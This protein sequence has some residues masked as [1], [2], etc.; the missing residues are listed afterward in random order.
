M[1]HTTSTLPLNHISI[2]P[3]SDLNFGLE[4]DCISQRTGFWEKLEVLREATPLR[5]SD[6]KLK[7]DHFHQKES[8]CICQS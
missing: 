1:Q 6:L 5:S 4:H 7:L 8:P 3:K 2:C